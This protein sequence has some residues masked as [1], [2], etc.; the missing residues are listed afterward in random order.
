[1]LRC[2]H[3]IAAARDFRRELLESEPCAGDRAG[4]WLTS[5]EL[6]NVLLGRAMLPSMGGAAQGS[7][8]GAGGLRGVGVGPVPPGA[9][10]LEVPKEK[11]KIVGL[12]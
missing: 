5:G 2:D 11:K 9:E 1:M 12:N 7:F 8:S 4:R 10:F 6:A 3:R